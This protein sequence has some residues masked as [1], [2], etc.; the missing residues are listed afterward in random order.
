MSGEVGD[1]PF[2]IVLDIKSRITEQ[3]VDIFHRRLRMHNNH[4]FFIYI[5]FVEHVGDGIIAVGGDWMFEQWL[6]VVM[7]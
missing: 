6:Q 1:V 3:T 7:R 4:N 2:S 5:K